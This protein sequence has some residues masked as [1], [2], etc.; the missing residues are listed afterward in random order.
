MAPKKGAATT[1]LPKPVQ[2]VRDELAAKGIPWDKD[3]DAD[4]LY[5]NVDKKVREAAQSALRSLLKAQSGNSD[6]WVK[7]VDSTWKAFLS[8]A[9]M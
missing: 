9:L 7:G 5:A 1:K 4:T 2:T 6:D 3:L 8:K